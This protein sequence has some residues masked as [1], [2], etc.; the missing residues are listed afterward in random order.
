MLSPPSTLLLFSLMPLQKEQALGTCPSIPLA[1]PKLRRHSREKVFSRT[2][3]NHWQRLPRGVVGAPSLEV[4]SHPW[5]HSRLWASCSNWICPCSLWGSWTR[6][7]WKVSFNLNQPMI[8]WFLG[9]KS[10]AIFCS[11][12][13][14][15]SGSQPAGQQARGCLKGKMPAVSGFGCSGQAAMTRTG[16]IKTVRKRRALPGPC[17]GKS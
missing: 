5:K 15:S 16:F 10:F 8:L 9:T 11:C 4:F 12:W 2:V 7:P 3:E 1:P 17:F 14:S 13:Q 6:W